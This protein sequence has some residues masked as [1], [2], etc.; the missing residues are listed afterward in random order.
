MSRYGVE[1]NCFDLPLRYPMSAQYWPLL[2]QCLQLPGSGLMTS[3]GHLFFQLPRLT[4]RART[5]LC[6]ELQP[7]PQP[8]LRFSQRWEC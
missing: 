7:S 6:Q 5:P 2:Q 1:Q 8:R 4:F 3:G